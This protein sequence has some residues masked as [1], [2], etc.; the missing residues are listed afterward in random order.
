MLGVRSKA[1]TQP[2]G[3]DDTIG[4]RMG[5]AVA[6][7]RGLATGVCRDTIVCIVADRT[8]CDFKFM[9]ETSFVASS[10]DQRRDL[11]LASRPQ[12]SSIGVMTSY[13]TLNIYIVSTTIWLPCSFWS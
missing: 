8:S 1:T 10:T 2:V 7:A 12:L 11:R 13:S 5:R 6:R 9:A 3:R 4:L